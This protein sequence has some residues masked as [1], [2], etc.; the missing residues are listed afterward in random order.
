MEQT[1][2]LKYIRIVRQQPESIKKIDHQILIEH[3]EICLEVIQINADNIKFIPMDVR[4]ALPQI[5]IDA[6][7]QNP[8]NI[9][10]VPEKVQNQYPQM[11]LDA[12]KKVKGILYDISIDVLE[13]NPEICLEALLTDSECYEDIPEEIIEE[14]PELELMRQV[15]DDYTYAEQISKEDLIKYPQIYLKSLQGK[16]ENERGSKLEDIVELDL[17]V[18][19]SSLVERFFEKFKMSYETASKLVASTQDIEFIKRIL[20]EKKEKISIQTLIEELGDRNSLIDDLLTN[21][22]EYSFTNNELSEIVFGKNDMEYAID[23]FENNIWQEN[24]ETSLIHLPKGMTIGIE[25]ECEGDSSKQILNLE[26]LFKGWEIKEDATLGEWDE[27]EKKSKGGVEV[28]SPVLQAEGK[29]ESSIYKTCSF[30]DWAGQSI[31]EKCGGHV[32]I[33]ADY[34]K[35]INAWKN[36]VEIWSNTEKMLFLISNDAGNLPRESV[37]EFAGPIL[38]K[39]QQALDDEDIELD[40]ED[41]ITQFCEQLKKVQSENPNDVRYSAINFENFG[42]ENKNTIEFRLSN[43]TLNPRT[44]IEN[45]NLFGGI[46]AAAQEVSD[47]QH[48]LELGQGLSKNEIYKLDKYELLKTQISDQEKLTALLDLVIPQENQTIY[49]N[50]YRVNSSLNQAYYFD[51]NNILKPISIGR[52]KL[53]RLAFTGEEQITGEEYAKN[54]QI[55]QNELQQENDIKKEES[56][57][58]SL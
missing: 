17:I 32:H 16:L 20:K 31:T 46:I 29:N 39:L 28:V 48:K 3:P 11:C 14:H 38:E 5:C 55:I 2:M 12:V 13:S 57:G 42:D 41:D 52:K 44:W 4:E 50:R 47:I 43:G 19:N 6:V 53:A 54:V 49:Q 25:I 26:E 58:D 33:G 7:K 36:L 56:K 8:E 40:S 9:M 37:F 18:N 21:K 22:D 51:K 34:L 1:E 35:D 15:I 30:L 24:I 10:Y 45:I 27:D 23:F